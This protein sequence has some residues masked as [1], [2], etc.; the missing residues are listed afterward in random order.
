MQVKKRLDYQLEVAN[1]MRRMEQKH[2]VDWI[3]SHVRYSTFTVFSS[4]AA[5]EVGSALR[6]IWHLICTESVPNPHLL[7]SKTFLFQFPINI[8]L[9]QR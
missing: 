8:F 7:A 3:I 4:A 6:S 1:V 9:N 5:T 2:M